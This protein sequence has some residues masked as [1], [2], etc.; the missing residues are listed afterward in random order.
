MELLNST[1]FLAEKSVLLVTC[2]KKGKILSLL[3]CLIGV[4]GI[5]PCSVVLRFSKITSIILYAFGFGLL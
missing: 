3:E 5:G 1:H 4:L 2:G